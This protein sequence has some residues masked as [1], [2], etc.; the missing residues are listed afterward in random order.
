MGRASTYGFINA[1]LRARI[2][3][4]LSRDWMLHMAASHSLSEAVALLVG[5]RYESASTVYQK[6][7]DLKLVEVE[8][9]RLEREDILG[10]RSVLTG[11]AADL[12]GAVL[13]RY[14]VEALK[15]ALRVWFSRV[16][17]GHPIEDVIP[18][19]DRE[20]AGDAFPVDSVVNA[21]DPDGL[22]LSLRGT[23]YEKIAGEQLPAVSEQKSL[24]P[25]ELALD[26]WYFTEL[27]TAINALDSEDARVARRFLGV[28]V[29]LLNL[30]WIVHTREFYK[31]PEARAMESLLPGGAV[32]NDRVISTV[33]QADSPVEAISAV[34][35]GRYGGADVF[36]GESDE[37]RKL[38]LLSAVLQEVLIHEVHRVMGGYPFSIGI[39]LAYIFL[40]QNE[41]RMITTVLNARYYELAPDAIGSML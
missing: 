32:F 27:R 2:S 7:G 21:P 15:N 11:P 30:H 19:L 40:R 33:Y 31:L 26:R 38:T 8:I 22:L 24:F 9:S 41:A 39:V 6:T 12:A 18:Y 13:M 29:D 20:T 28:Q 37:T 34:L 17:A 25:L 10:I 36:S 35:S 23:A 3:T 1:K 4:M 16:I 14:E 5:T